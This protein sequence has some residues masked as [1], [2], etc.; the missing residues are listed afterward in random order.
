MKYKKRTYKN[1]RE[2]F[3]DLWFPIRNR[4]QLKEITGKKLISTAFRE[5]LMLAVTAVN[6]CRYCSYFHSK[7][8]LKSGVTSEEISNLL[9][10]DVANCPQDE[11]VAVIYAQH[12]AE[13]VAHPDPEAV[14]R[15]QETYGRE[16]TEAIH[17]MLRMIRTGNLLGN[18]WDYLI[19]RISFGRKRG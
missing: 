10:G 5:R 1:L 13:S 4:S 9:S 18:S 17:L 11:A 2:L 16:K 7:Q 14:K 19:Y 8:A 6:G 12:W 3:S 15:L